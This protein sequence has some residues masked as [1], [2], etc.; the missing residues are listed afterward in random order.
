LRANELA[1][2][3]RSNL[4]LD[5]KVP[6]VT[7]WN[8]T[9]KNAKG[10][11]VPLLPSAVERLRVHCRDMLP[12]A[13]L[14]SM[15]DSRHVA[16]MFRTDLLPAGIP[17]VDAARLFFDFHCLRACTA[18]F[19]GDA[20]VPVPVIRD[21]MRHADIQTTMRYVKTNVIQSRAQ[22][23]TQMPSL[24][25]VER[26]VMEATND[27]ALAV[28]FHTENAK[29]DAKT[30]GAITSS[31]C[32]HTDSQSGGTDSDVCPALCRSCSGRST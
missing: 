27:K 15:P 8:G 11:D 6:V 3:C 9:D 32:A 29:Q 18:S 28:G 12:G 30:E 24:D 14:F 10:V 23:L 25:A 19:L 4:K 26:L 21:I 17:Y 5:E 1:C 20:G 16:E 7:I 2:L 31:A 22:A 13:R